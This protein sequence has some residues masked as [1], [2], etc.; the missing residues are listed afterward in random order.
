MHCQHESR[1]NRFL[2][3]AALTV[4]RVALCCY[5]RISNEDIVVWFAARQEVK[6][7]RS[8]RRWRPCPTISFW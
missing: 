6:G 8:H 3:P 5:A 2:V 1:T 7:S 4:R